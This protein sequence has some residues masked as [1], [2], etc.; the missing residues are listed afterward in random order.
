MFDIEPL[1][2]TAV[3]SL[4]TM[5]IASIHHANPNAIFLNANENAFGSPLGNHLHRYPDM[6]Q[7]ALKIKISSI[8]GVPPKN[9][10]LGNG[11]D[12]AIDIIIRVFCEPGIDHV[13]VCPPSFERY[14]LSTQIHGANVKSVPLLPS[15]Q[16]D[17]EKILEAQNEHSKLLFLC[18][19]NNPTANSFHPD[20][21]ELLIQKF[22]GIVVLDEAYIN[23]AR[24][25]SGIRWLLEYENLIVLQTFSTA[26]GLAG[27]RVGMAFAAQNIVDYMN[28]VKPPFN[29]SQTT[30]DLTIQ[31][32]DEMNW[33]NDHIRQTVKERDSLAIRLSEVKAVEKVFPSDANFL[34]VKFTDAHS[35]QTAL[36]EAGI[37]VA[38]MGH[39]FGCAN[40]LRIT[41]GTAEENE[42]LMAV[43][44][45]AGE[46]TKS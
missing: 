18:S 13:I 16:L 42:R 19:P 17:A 8:K 14:A 34:M 12:E 4:P 43:L 5:S 22:K 27:L 21:I 2:R 10:F 41:V 30:Q 39:H 7:L 15:F 9:I 44:N 45:G 32:L 3:K 38:Q 31:A 33:V 28:K 40:C 20:D 35:V 24:Q 1:V 36:T 25:R 46:N 29:L 26:W 23:Y 6:E 37:Y 11:S